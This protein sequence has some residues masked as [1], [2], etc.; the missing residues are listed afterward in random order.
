MGI[1]GGISGRKPVHRISIPVSFYLGPEISQVSDLIQFQDHKAKPLGN[2]P[3]K[4]HHVTKL[5]T[6]RNTRDFA[7]DSIRLH[8]PDLEA[9]P[10]FSLNPSRAA[11]HASSCIVILDSP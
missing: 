3:L 9:R 8:S 5:R 7:A 2:D 11:Y 1:S 10:T 4:P 6:V